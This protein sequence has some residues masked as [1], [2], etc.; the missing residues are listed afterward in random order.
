MNNNNNKNTNDLQIYIDSKFYSTSDAKISVF[1]HGLMYGDGIYEALR[2][3]DGKI[4]KIDDHVNRLFSSA[5]GISLKIPT[6]KEEIKSALY[7]TIWKNNLP[8]AYLRLIVTRGQGKM[9]VDPRNCAKPTIIIIPEIRPPPYRNGGGVSVI[10]AKSVKRTPKWALD[11]RIKSLNY[12][13]NILAKIEAIN[14][15]A[16]DAI[17]LN[18]KGHISEAS[19]GNV[20]LVN[21]NCITTPPVSAGILE[22]IT[23]KAII[24]I[25]RDSKLRFQ[26]KTVRETD[27]LNADEVFLSGT[28]VE[29]APVLKINRRKINSG[30]VG[31]I[32]QLLKEKFIELT[33]K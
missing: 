14:E 26:E 15:D 7:Q 22:G 4:F 16:D 1:D 13:N 33:T 32:T 6:R 2:A 17:L 12:L 29:I 11:P 5:S 23:R 3:Y 21:D 10:I 24:E 27:L 20:F 30:K 8:N 19:T 25:I 28:S 31:S 18:E 9:G